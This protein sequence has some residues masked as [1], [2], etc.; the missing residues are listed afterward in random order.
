[1]TLQDAV[2]HASGL[3]Q[4]C[5]L[6]VMQGDECQEIHTDEHLW[7]FTG[8]RHVNSGMRGKDQ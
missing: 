2:E 6:W 7:A 3:W 5:A 8:S 1:M 4:S